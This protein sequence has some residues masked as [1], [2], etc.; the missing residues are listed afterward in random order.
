[1]TSGHQK[2]PNFR[3]CSDVAGDAW[4]EKRTCGWKCYCCLRRWVWYRKTLH[5]VHPGRW[6]AQNL[7]I[8]TH[9]VL[10][11]DL[12]QPN[13]H[14]IHVPAVHL[15][16]CHQLRLVVYAIISSD[17]IYTYISKRWLALIYEPSTLGNLKGHLRRRHRS[18]GIEVGFAF[19]TPLGGWPKR[20]LPRGRKGNNGR[21]GYNPSPR[22]TKGWFDW[23][24]CFF[25]WW[26]GIGLMFFFLWWDMISSR[27][28][29]CLLYICW[30]FDWWRGDMGMNKMCLFWSIY[31]ILL[32]LMMQK[33]NSWL[34]SVPYHDVQGIG[35]NLF[36]LDV[37][38][39]YQIRL[40]YTGTS[41][42]RTWFLP[43]GIIN[44]TPLP[45]RTLPSFSKGLNLMAFF[46]PSPWWISIAIL[47]NGYSNPSQT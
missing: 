33:E 4:R 17:F 14:G 34:I 11:H 46:S 45:H 28:F 3:V 2:T 32:L 38:F 6:T 39:W 21:W 36:V 35:F 29:F 23:C 26:G 47:S 25:F 13:L 12:N 20:P 19:C 1:M 9:F 8:I 41:H 22:L 30:C 27:T 5:P 10:E 7:Q 40:T 24:W 43:S 15:Q 44:G 18:L 31:H 16:G 42:D 37:P